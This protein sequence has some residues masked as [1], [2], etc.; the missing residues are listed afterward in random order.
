[1]I[2]LLYGSCSTCRYLA[3]WEVLSSSKEEFLWTCNCGADI[4]RPTCLIRRPESQAR[5]TNPGA[6]MGTRRR[7][8]CPAEGKIPSTEHDHFPILLRRKEEGEG[9]GVEYGMPSAK[10]VSQSGEGAKVPSLNLARGNYR[11]PC[12]IASYPYKSS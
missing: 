10:A 9:I 5:R 8:A 4:W 11:V 12:A 1:M 6:P 7:H 3:D 2:S